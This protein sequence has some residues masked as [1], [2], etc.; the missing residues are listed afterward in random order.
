MF[1][2]PREEKEREALPLLAL[3]PG[4]KEFHS[5]PGRAAA[6]Q[7]GRER[8]ACWPLDLIGLTCHNKIPQTSV[9]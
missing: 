8:V 5:N 3:R 2:N 1:G 7:K 4:R 6:E 9:T